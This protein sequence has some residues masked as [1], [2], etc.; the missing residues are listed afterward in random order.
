MNLPELRVELH[1]FL[2]TLTAANDG[3]GDRPAET[4]AKSLAEGL[5]IRNGPTVSNHAQI[6]RRRLEVV[7]HSHVTVSQKALLIVLPRYADRG[8]NSSHFPWA[9]STEKASNSPCAV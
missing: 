4:C 5:S 8:T 2:N 7:L 1:S 6:R 3:E 9:P